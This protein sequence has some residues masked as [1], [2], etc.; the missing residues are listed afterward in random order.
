MRMHGVLTEHIREHIER[1][2][3]IQAMLAREERAGVADVAPRLD[4]EV[5]HP[6]PCPGYCLHVECIDAR[7]IA[8]WQRS[9]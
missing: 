1:N 6:V 5:R 7:T 8:F 9:S 2:H 4:D 3:E